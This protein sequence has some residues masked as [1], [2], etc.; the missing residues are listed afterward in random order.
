MDNNN[1]RDFLKHSGL[2]LGSLMLSGSVLGKGAE[3]INFGGSEF[4]LGEIG[5]FPYDFIPKG[6]LACDGQLLRV[7]T[8]QALFS[9]LGTRYG[10]NG[11]L[12]FGLPDL[13]GRVPIGFGLTADGNTLY[14]MGAKGGTE[15]HT[16]T[17]SQ[18]PA[19][20]HGVQNLELKKRV[21]GNVNQAFPTN[22]I[23]GKNTNY[24]NR[25]SSSY[26]EENAPLI[27]EE[28]MSA[29]GS[30]PHMNMQPFLALHFCIAV[31]GIYPPR[32]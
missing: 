32:P 12:D 4:Y 28:N 22:A 31:N 20:N 13:R 2:L 29:G 26:D 16:L 21:G 9:L 19:H 30:Q 5:I 27:L 10:G 24:P 25:F 8:N 14:N 11:I 15:S 17:E 23:P 7:N 6:W 18:L 3:G 1:R